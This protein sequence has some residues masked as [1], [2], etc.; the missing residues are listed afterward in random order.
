MLPLLLYSFCPVAILHIL[1]SFS[2]SYSTIMLCPIFQA[3]KLKLG[4]LK[5]AL[6]DTEFA[7]RDGDNNAKA[8]FRQGQVGIAIEELSIIG[9]KLLLRFTT[10]ASCC[11][12]LMCPH[13]F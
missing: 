4:D 10:W 2:F 12:Y 9:W 8:L 7:I 1:T 13:F 11:W 6:L 5:G 3:C